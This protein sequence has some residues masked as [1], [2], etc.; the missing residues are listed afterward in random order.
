MNEFMDRYLPVIILTGVIYLVKIG[1]FSGIVLAVKK[2]WV[3][4]RSRKS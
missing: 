4:L 3:Y 1:G 2:L